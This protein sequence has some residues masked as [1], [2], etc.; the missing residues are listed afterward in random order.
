M[1]IAVTGGSGFLG[2]HVVQGLAAAG[3]DVV[4]LDLVYPQWLDDDRYTDLP[5]RFNYE[6]LEDPNSIRQNCHGA[7]VVMHLAAVSNTRAAYRDPAGCMQVNSVGT[8]N[9]Y[10]AASESETIER[11]VLASSSLVSGAQQTSWTFEDEGGTF[12]AVSEDDPFDLA[13]VKHPYV[14]SKIHGEMIAEVFG[15]QYNV[16]STVFRYGIQYGRN[17]APGVVAHAFVTR[18]LAGQPLIINGSGEQWRQ[19][20]HVGDIANAHWMLIEQGLNA[21]T[22]GTFNIVGDQRVTINEMAHVVAELTN[23]THEQGPGRLDDIEVK[24]CS[25]ER[26]EKVMG[27]TPQITLKQGLADTVEWY[28]SQPTLWTGPSRTGLAASNGR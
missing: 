7:R 4:V 28:R 6:D 25:N 26:A 8:Q 15:H 14:M 2:Q 3:H 22:L 23:V 13:E 1:K 21:E 20:T 10:I 11:V 12:D 24:Y 18:G 17:M 9:V 16:Q 19:Y 5:I 27:W